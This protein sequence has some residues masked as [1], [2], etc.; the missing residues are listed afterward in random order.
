MLIGYA[1]VSTD[2]QNLSLQYDSL[3]AAGCEK[4]FSDKASGA[5]NS[6]PGL[7]QALSHLR[8][9]D[10]LVV[11]KLDRLGRT[12][13]GL[14]ELV[15]DLEQKNIQ[16]RSATDG[17]DTST[18]SGRFFFH[19]MSALAQ[20]ER[21]LIAERTKAGLAAARARGKLGGRK[22]KMTDSKLESAQKL[23]D[24]GMHPKSVAANLGVSVQTL[25]RW[26]PAAGQ[27]DVAVKN[28]K[29][30]LFIG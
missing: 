13:K 2:D 5:A 4:I 19:V 18:S 8:P 26:I 17:I 3:T 30:K 23:L 14:V 24:G 20:M 9:G 15:S 29:R 6:R 7:D 28:G 12:V 27:S 1:R 10:T 21:E 25:Y 16:F 11:W 22:R